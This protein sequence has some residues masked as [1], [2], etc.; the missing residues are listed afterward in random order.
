MQDDSQEPTSYSTLSGSDSEAVQA[1]V[2][3]S[4][5]EGPSG[6]A[7]LTASFSTVTLAKIMLDDIAI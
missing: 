2:V 5:L 4:E 1:T 3:K 7:K 6:S